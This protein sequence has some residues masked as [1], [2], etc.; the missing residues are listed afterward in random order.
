MAEAL[1]AGNVSAAL[2]T[3]AFAGV[4]YGA[5]LQG[6]VVV[7][8]IVESNRQRKAQRG[9][10]EASLQDR[11]I[12]IR[13]SEAPRNIVYGSTRVSGPLI[14]ACSHGDDS[15]FVTMVIALASHPIQAI[16]EVWLND[17]S[18]GSLDGSY[19]VTGGTY[20][21]SKP[22]PWVHTPSPVAWPAN[23]GT[24]VL[25]F[26]P[27][28]I[29]SI[30]VVDGQGDNEY[31]FNLVAGEHY[32]LSGATIT[33]IGSQYAGLDTVI[34]YR[35]DD[36]A[37]L[38]RAKPFLGAAAGQRDTDLET[39][40]GGEW[41]SAHLLKGVARVHVTLEYDQDIFPSGAPNI[42]AVVRG[43]KVYDPRTSTTGYSNNPALCVADY[44]TSDLGF[45]CSSNEIDWDTV[46][47]AA[48]ICEETVDISGSETQ[49]RY[50]CDG[51]VYCNAGRRENLQ[52]LLSS[53]LGTAV[54]SGGKW[55]IFAGAY[56][57]PI[58]DLDESDLADG[59]I[60]VT[61]YQK[62]A[63]VFNAVRGQYINPDQYYKPDDFTPYASATYAADDGETAY[64]DFDFP[65]T[66]N[67]IRA[68]RLARLALYRA[69]QAVTFS[70]TF[71][72]GALGIQPADRVRVTMADFGWSLKVFRVLDRKFN[73]AAMTVTL[74]MQEDASAVYADGYSDLTDPDPAPNTALPSAHTVAALQG[75]TVTSDATTYTTSPD[76][77]V[78]PYLLA[79]WDAI[80]D[81]G[82]LRG[83]E[84]RLFWKRA[85]ETEWRRVVLRPDEVSA[86]IE[87]VSRLETIN[88]YAYNVNGAQATSASVFATVVVSADIPAVI[89]VPPA[90]N[91]IQNASLLWGDDDW[92]TVDDGLGGHPG[93]SFAREYYQTGT[94]VGYLPGTPKAAR[95]IHQG[96]GTI[97]G[98]ARNPGMA[99][100]NRA[101]V[102]P[103]SYV[104]A[105]MRV[106]SRNTR[107]WIELRWY[108]SA[109]SVIAVTRSASSG[110][111]GTGDPSAAARAIESYERV[112]LIASVPATAK[113]VGYEWRTQPKTSGAL[114]YCD[115]Y[116]C[117]H[118][119]HVSTVKPGKVPEWSDGPPAS[120]PWS[121]VASGADVTVLW[122]TTSLGTSISA[123]GVGTQVLLNTG[124]DDPFPFQC[125]Y[126]LSVSVD[127][128]Y[129]ASTG[130]QIRVDGWLRAT[131]NNVLQDNLSAVSAPYVTPANGT[132]KATVTMETQQTIPAWQKMPWGLM[133]QLSGSAPAANVSGLTIRYKLQIQRV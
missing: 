97:V 112:T 96:D 57:T 27:T 11:T 19:Y 111:Y 12:A 42:S 102:A 54:Y 41:T 69:R 84:T 59:A 1:I 44:L 77:T 127:C 108:D 25:A 22:T 83:G 3:T 132:A 117:A 30:T 114:S 122:G 32:S 94:H 64:R 14:Y 38:V 24:I 50:T 56:E 9:A 43:A 78:R 7:Y 121:A 74:T 35:A 90:G 55:R 51:V 29:D 45:G 47:A 61:G 109:G 40:S 103:G 91:Q 58:A 8:G 87:P 72:L 46:E 118:Q 88:V 107:A 124:L 101:A 126:R 99:A 93:E 31:S 125:S 52:A 16:D 26:T 71:K 89:E 81:S 98:V 67:N 34:T 76:G 120:T 116:H 36:N 53:M 23:G 13:S 104:A 49:Q 2:A 48:D 62:A 86:R 15:E 18:I 37:A 68:Q 75:F 95:W 73:P 65:F 63:D 100:P 80:T 113:S 5:L 20:Y 28:A 106:I 133:L 129:Y 82:V 128:S 70:A 60:S 115:V 105:A 131:V 4:T 119:L 66:Q 17:A 79:Q 39:N 123:I 92:S 130:G 110:D 10:Y 21:K 33:A 6:A 85:Q